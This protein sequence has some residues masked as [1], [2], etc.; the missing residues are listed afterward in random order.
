VQQSQSWR[1]DINNSYAT[2][3]VT[4]GANSEVGGF[5]GENDST[6]ENS[7]STGAVTSG[8]GSFVGGFDGAGGEFTFTDCYWDTTTSG[9]DQGTGGGNIDGITGLTTEQLQSGLP[10]GFDPAVWNEQSGVNT[11]FPYL[12]AIPPKK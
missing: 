6:I 11:G 7:Y 10:S 1:A 8:T 2:G 9:T 12:I 5:I 3:A 4:G